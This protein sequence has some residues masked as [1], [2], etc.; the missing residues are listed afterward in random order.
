LQ[1]L[2]AFTTVMAP[3]LCHTTED[4]F[5]YSSL[6]KEN[7][8]SIFHCGWFVPVRFWGRREGAS[9]SKLMILA[10]VLE[11]RGNRAHVEKI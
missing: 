7:R 11:K 2:Q 6:K 10:R 4:I 9:S 8:E 3:I 5:R 1:I